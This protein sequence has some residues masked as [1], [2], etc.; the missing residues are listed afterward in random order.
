MIYLVQ[1]LDIKIQ[2]YDNN[3]F[4]NKIGVKPI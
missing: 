4:V 3:V 1:D 2:C